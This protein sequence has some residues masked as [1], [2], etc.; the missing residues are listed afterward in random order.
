[1]L[2]APQRKQAVLGAKPKNLVVGPGQD[3]KTVQPE[4][5]KCAGLK[6]EQRAVLL[7]LIGAWVKM[8]PADA[9]SKRMAELKKKI[10][11][12][13]F[14]WYGA[15]E[16]GGAAY[17]RIQGPTLVIEYAPQ[18]SVS[19]IHTIIRDPRNDYGNELTKS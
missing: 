7:E 17:Y 10:D 18:G 15:T 11:E 4:G 9:A 13:Y 1:M 16:N 3:G 5:L 8:L 14:V 2:D 6:E 19:H 12:T